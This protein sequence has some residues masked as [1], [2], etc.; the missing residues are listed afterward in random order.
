MATSGIAQGINK[1]HV[2]EKRAKPQRYCRK[3]AVSSGVVMLR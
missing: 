3:S 1:G 2:V